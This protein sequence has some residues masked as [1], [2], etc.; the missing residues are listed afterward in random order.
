MP[1]IINVC[2]H[3]S[4]S[5]HAHIILWL[6]DEDADEAYKKIV[7]CMPAAWDPQAD[8]PPTVGGRP[9]QYGADGGEGTDGKGNWVR[10]TEPFQARV[11]DIV[12]RKQMHRCMEL[13][14]KGG[15]RQD[16]DRYL[17]R[18]KCSGNFP[19]D[20]Q[21]FVSPQY[22]AEKGVFQY[23]CPGHEHRNVVPYCPVSI[24]QW[25]CL[26]LSIVSIILH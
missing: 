14:K 19:Q 18:H 2:S 13:G 8:G 23:Y 5:V 12:K 6:N 9:A 22:N 3:L 17:K 21:G 11:F 16:K 26:V 4:R 10:P 20:L 24:S 15:C 25:P 7:A 1:L